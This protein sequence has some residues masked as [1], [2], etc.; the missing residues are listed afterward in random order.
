MIHEIIDIDCKS[1]RNLLYK[2]N[3][4]EMLK[5]LKQRSTRGARRSG[6][7]KPSNKGIQFD[8]NDHCVLYKSCWKILQILL[9][10]VQINEHGVSNECAERH[11]NY[12]C[13]TTLRLVIT[14][15]YLISFIISFFDVSAGFSDNLY[16]NCS[17]FVTINYN[18]TTLDS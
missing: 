8:M 6:W 17:F 16:F 15:V 11:N 1:C 12:C 2:H 4:I 10:L 5:H 14:F 9:S 3:S 7:K 18:W 13:N